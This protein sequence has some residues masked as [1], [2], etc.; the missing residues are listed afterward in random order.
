[1]VIFDVANG[2]E[3]EVIF[4]T[5]EADIE[6]INYSR[7]NKKLLSVTWTTDKDKEHFFDAEAEA[8]KKE[9]EAKMVQDIR[10]V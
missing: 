9:I 2:K 10:K 6:G 5:E 1:M 3:A 4:Q 8:M 7:K